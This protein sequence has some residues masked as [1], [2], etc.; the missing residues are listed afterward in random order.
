M[1][2]YVATPAIDELHTEDG[3][4]VLREANLVRLGPIGSVIRQ[5]THDPAS[6]THLNDALVSQFGVPDGDSLALT[7]DAVDTLVTEGLLV[8]A[9]G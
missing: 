7:R 4:L 6:L 8:V 5:A 1:T 3:G 2:R 9:D